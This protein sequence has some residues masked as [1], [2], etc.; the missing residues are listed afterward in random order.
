MPSTPQTSSLLRPS[1]SRRST[2][3]RWRSGSRLSASSSRSC[4]PVANS[5]SS[6]SSTQWRGGDIQAPAASK[7]ERSTA[8]PASPI[9]RL[10][11]SPMPVLL[12]RLTRIWSSQVLKE[13][14]PAN[15]SSPRSTATQVSCTTS[16]ATAVLG[17]KAVA[18]RSIVAWWRAARA[19]KADSAPPRSFSTSSASAAA[20]VSGRRGPMG[21]QASYGAHITILE[22]R[23]GLPGEALEGDDPLAA[24]GTRDGDRAD[25]GQGTRG[26]DRELVDGARGAALD[27]EVTPVGGDGRV[28]GASAGFGRAERAQLAPGGDPD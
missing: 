7:R 24:D 12:A 8:G 19:V 15:P 23:R 28:D 18:S 11:A 16:S 17:T 10:R 20:A 6:L 26:A 21:H 14:R 9:G 25:F 13:E 2:I 22:T 4:S 1:T 5:R 3:A 27:V